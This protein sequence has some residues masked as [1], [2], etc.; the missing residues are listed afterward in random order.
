MVFDEYA[1]FM[2]WPDKEIMVKQNEGLLMYQSKIKTKKMY[3][4]KCKYIYLQVN[5]SLKQLKG[6]YLRTFV[7]LVTLYSR[8]F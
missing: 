3:T 1:A 6:E 7:P 2:W 5:V 8:N 4:K